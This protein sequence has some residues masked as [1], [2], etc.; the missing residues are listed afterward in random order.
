M[1]IL[2][3]SEATGWT[4]GATQILLTAKRLIARGHKLGVACD[5]EG[6]MGRRLI[7]EGVPVLPYKVRQDYDIPGAWRLA[8]LAKEWGASVIHAHHPKA[9]AM[10]ML[11]C[12]FLGI[13]SVV[14]RRVITPMGSNPF[15]R[16]KYSSRRIRRYVAVCDAAAIE[17][18]K[19]GVESERI[20]VIPSGV[21]M[22]P[23]EVSRRARAALREKRSP[24]AV[25]VA[26]YS[27]IKGHDILLQ[28]LPT[29]LR[30]VPD[31]R[32]RLIGRD[33]EALLPRARELGVARCLE[34]LGSRQD[35]PEQLAQAH[36]FVMPSLQEGIGT[37]LI[38]AQAGLVPAVASAVGGLPQVLEHGR[39]G[40]LVKPGDPA[41]LA[42]GM[43]RQLKD[44]AEA[45]R[46]AE[47][48]FTRVG[49]RFSID[50]AVDRLESLYRSIA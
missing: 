44:T 32:M 13:A 5:A 1:N 42:W 41:E 45:E 31:L 19:A 24:V 28:A 39:T 25:M 7:R 46:M 11:S 40:L 23:W 20:E 6:E 33:T 35:V 10:V 14:T 47:A 37:A 9:H 17:L 38:E 36:L 49:G 34:L 8:R 2:Y 48:G 27:P 30:E 4:G 26:H 12:F 15:S 21:D 50:S 43:I 3:V 16:F 18:Q 22:D 29:V